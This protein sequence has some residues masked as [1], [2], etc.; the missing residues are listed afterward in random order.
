MR[1]D[2]VIHV[3]PSPFANSSPN[4]VGGMI[5]LHPRWL[6]LFLLTDIS[7]KALPYV[8][9]PLKEYIVSSISGQM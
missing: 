2:L 4:G 1:D 9:F 3:L 8:F 5:E 6:L 7:N